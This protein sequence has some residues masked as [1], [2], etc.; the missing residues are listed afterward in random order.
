MSNIF[1]PEPIVSGDVGIWGPK[2][3]DQ[4]RPAIGIN[5]C[6]LY[7]DSGTLKLSTG[8]IGYYTGSKYGFVYVDTVTTISIAGISASDWAY[9]YLTVTGTTPTFAASTA[10]SADYY[11]VTG[12]LS[13]NY[14]GAYGGFYG[15]LGQRII[16]LAWKSSGSAL[17]G[18][19]NCASIDEKYAGWGTC[20]TTG[21]IYR[22][23]KNLDTNFE[24]NHLGDQFIFLESERPSSLVLSSG[25][26]TTFTDVNCS[27]L[28]PK[29]VTALIFVCNFNFGGDG[30]KDNT[31]AYFRKNGSAETDTNR[32]FGG[33]NGF[34]NLGVGIIKYDPFYIE[35]LCDIDGIFEY[36]LSDAAGALNMRLV[37]YYVKRY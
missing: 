6:K 23:E 25:S 9:I 36:K 26:A 4:N 10:A 3:L 15:P 12:L 24:A 33:G 32:T 22:F 37:G 19:V 29:G 13:T 34:T 5:T 11:T 31:I 14:N 21:H 20:P 7:N 30:A 18:V 28:V 1:K 16:G 17:A 35:I 27:A 8:I 2:Q